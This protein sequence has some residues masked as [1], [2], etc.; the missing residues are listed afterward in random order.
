MVEANRVYYLKNLQL[1]FKKSRQAVAGTGSAFQWGISR[2]QAL[3][4][5]SL[6]SSACLYLPSCLSLS[7]AKMIPTNSGMHVHFKGGRRK[8]AVLASLE[9]KD[10]PKGPYWPDLNHMVIPAAKEAGNMRIWLRWS[11]RR[12][13]GM[14]VGPASEYCLP[15]V[16][17]LKWGKE[18]ACVIDFLSST[19]TWW[20]VSIP[21]SC[22]QIVDAIASERNVWGCSLL[23][24]NLFTSEWH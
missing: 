6:A 7:V 10:F 16:L 24:A 11:G 3:F 19:Q 4:I 15:Y 13:F 1:L 12:R 2:T 20:P 18:W 14:T 5:S 23:E 9:V 21:C 8:G 22:C 17:S